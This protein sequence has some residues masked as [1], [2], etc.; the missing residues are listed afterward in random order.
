MRKNKK[1]VLLFVLLFVFAFLQT[2]ILKADLSG[3]QDKLDESVG[4]LEGV[5]ENI[6]TKWDYLGKEWKNILLKNDIVKTA[7]GF[8]K[9]ISPAFVVLFGE[10]YSLSLTLLFIVVFWFL[11]FFK[12]KEILTDFSMFSPATSMII[13]F[14]LVIILGQVGGNL[15]KKLVGFLGWIVFSQDAWWARTILIVV[16]VFAIILISKMSSLFGEAMKKNREEL[17]KEQEKSDRKSLKSIV[18]SIVKG[19]KGD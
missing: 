3:T 2:A 4:N 6:E 14:G 19:L 13:S 5:Q 15:F 11:F 16:V 17:A 7:D 10:P 8:L 1:I 9:K 18:D 12:F